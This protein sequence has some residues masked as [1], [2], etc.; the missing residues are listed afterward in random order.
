M[1]S[2]PYTSRVRVPR[3]LVTYFN[4]FEHRG[5]GGWQSMG[6]LLKRKLESSSTIELSS[7]EVRRIADMARGQGGYQ[8]K[9]RVLLT[10]WLEQNAADPEIAESLK[11]LVQTRLRAPVATLF[12]RLHY[13][14]IGGVIADAVGHVSRAERRYFAE[15]LADVF[16]NHSG[17]RFDRDRWFV[18]CGLA[19]ADAEK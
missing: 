6:R 5:M 18:T 1:P 3:D 16:A 14:L 8:S 7:T 11:T 13:E 4:T 19:E 2:P 17:R 15:R 10:A 12:T 9:L